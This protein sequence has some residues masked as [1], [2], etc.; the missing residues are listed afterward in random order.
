[1]YAKA[2]ALLALS[3]LS[4]SAQAAPAASNSPSKSG[5]ASSSASVTASATETPVTLPIP[6][7]LGF[8]TSVVTLSYA[9]DWVNVHADGI[10]SYIG[11]SALQGVQATLGVM[12]AQKSIGTATHLTAF[13]ATDANSAPVVL[14]SSIGGSAIT[15]ATGTVGGTT[16]FGG[17]AFRT[18]APVVLDAQSSSSGSSSAASSTDSANSSSTSASS[19]TSGSNTTSS[20]SSTGT[21]KNNGG[22]VGVRVPQSAVVGALAVLGS[23]AMGA[24]AVL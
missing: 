19:S 12:D 18:A 1:M 22:S 24:V 10:A 11:S 2:F 4:L 17:Q 16:T 13:I 5:S 23:V 21:G 6:T 14:V 9:V 7:Q 8:P 3:V 15:L 20:A